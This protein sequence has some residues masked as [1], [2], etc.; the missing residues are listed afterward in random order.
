MNST[1]TPRL[2][3]RLNSLTSTRPIYGMIQTL[4]TSVVSFI[5]ASQII[6]SLLT[7]TSEVNSTVFLIWGVMFTLQTIAVIERILTRKQIQKNERK[8][9]AEL[10]LT[11]KDG[12]TEVNP[13]VNEV[14][15]SQALL[16]I[17]FFNGFSVNALFLPIA[18]I[19]IGF[20]ITF[21]INFN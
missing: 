9:I 7:M 6:A 1:I 11:N 3:N 16:S 2:I 14:F 8:L 12:E 17:N 13:E 20:I 19:D 5:V 18:I 4:A 10:A 21:V 15:V